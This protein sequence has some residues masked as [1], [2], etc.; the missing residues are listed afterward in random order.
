M[1]LKLITRAVK[2]MATGG[3]AGGAAAAAGSAA[4]KLIGGQDEKEVIESSKALNERAQQ[5]SVISK[6]AVI[7]TATPEA[8]K[9]FAAYLS[10]EVD[11]A[12]RVREEE[13]KNRI[14][15]GLRRE[16]SILSLLQGLKSSAIVL[17]SKAKFA[18]YDARQKMLQNQR[19]AEEQKLEG[20]LGD[21]ASDALGKVA[22][23]AGRVKDG[24]LAALSPFMTPALLFGGAFLAEKMQSLLPERFRDTDLETV[25][26]TVDMAADKVASL[27]ATVGLQ[28]M[29]SKVKAAGTVSLQKMGLVKPPSAA[30]TAAQTVVGKVNPQMSRYQRY[31]SKLGAARNWLVGLQKASNGI[32]ASAAKWM[33]NLPPKMSAFLKKTMGKVLKWFLIFEAISF[34][35][36]STQAFILGSIS[37]DEW[38]KRNKE[39]ITKII[40]LFGGPFLTMMIFAAAGTIVPVLGN[41]AGGTAGLIV[42]I[43]LGDQVFDV[44][45]MNLLVEGL[46][47]VFFLGKW[48]TLKSFASGLVGRIAIELPKMLAQF[49]WD[50]AKGIV[51]APLKIAEM[52][53]ADRIATDEEITAEYGEDVRGAELLMKAGEGMGTDENAILYAFK[54]IDTP[55]KYQFLKKD[56]EEKYL[57]QYNEGFGRNVDTMEEYLQ[58]ELGEDEFEQLKTQVSTQ[59]RENADND[60]EQLKTFLR[61][62]GIEETPTIQGIGEV[63]DEEYRRVQQGELVDVI[64]KDGSK[65]LMTEQELMTSDNVGIRAREIA[66]ERLERNRRIAANAKPIPQEQI[67]TSEIQQSIIATNEN[68]N[69]NIIPAMDKANQN[70]LVVNQAAQQQLKQSLPSVGTE[71]PSTPTSAMPSRRTTDA[72]VDLGYST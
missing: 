53:T 42:G 66:M 21:L 1:A 9:G 61:Q 57:P 2:A 71:G 40:R 54:D 65:T 62:V 25:L 58:K 29:A 17:E 14:Y 56:F 4:S 67:T 10:K 8:V 18:L 45:K 32:V 64:L 51:T 63:S 3:A 60:N 33:A 30:A 41:L 72:F 6:P 52:M 31:L 35:Y 37:K 26:D 27:S 59:M 13:I 48:D 69:Q 49:A 55:E 46:Y 15:G 5:E 24:V 44:L 16:D 22:G 23:Y 43:L 34:M 68:V 47:D 11:I 7:S 50:A 28:A 70:V 38:H 19:E 39:Q 20:G 36:N 12:E